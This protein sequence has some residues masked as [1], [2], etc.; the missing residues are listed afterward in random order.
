MTLLS[1]LDL[2]K[3]DK[4]SRSWWIHPLMISERVYTVRITIA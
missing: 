4:C 2:G 3:V 1:L